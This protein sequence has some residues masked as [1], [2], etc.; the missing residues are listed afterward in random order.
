MISLKR[1]GVKQP[2]HLQICCSVLHELPDSNSIKQFR[3]LLYIW[4]ITAMKVV[5]V[6]V[7]CASDDRVGKE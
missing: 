3:W 7:K 6:N 4:M 1:S 5:R 2:L